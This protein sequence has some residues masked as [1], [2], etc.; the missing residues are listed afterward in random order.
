M[1]LIASL[2]VFLI[3]S[4]GLL[5]V[6]GEN[7]IKELTESNNRLKQELVQSERY[8]RFLESQNKMLM[9]EME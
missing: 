8:V 6:D 5:V 7:R 1:K 2:I 3:A 9:E 4:L